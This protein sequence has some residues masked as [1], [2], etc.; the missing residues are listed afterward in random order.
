MATLAQTKK[1]MVI[2]GVNLLDGG[3]LTVLIDCIKAASQCISKEEWQILVFVHKKGLVP[4]MEGITQLEVPCAKKSWLRRMYVEWCHFPKV[5]SK[6]KPDV[7]LSLHDITPRI[8]ARKMAVYCHNPSPFLPLKLGTVLIDPKL[9]LFRLMYGALYAL[10]IQR[11]DWVIVQQNWMA[12]EFARRYKPRRMIVARPEPQSTTRVTSEPSAGSSPFVFFYPA[13]PRSFKNFEQICEALALLEQDP[14]WRHEI[15]FTVAGNENKYIRKVFSRYEH[16][17]SVRWLGLMPHPEVLARYGKAGCL[18]FPS[19]LETWGL[20]LSEAKASGLPILAVDLPYAH[21]TVGDYDKVDF[22]PVDDSATLAAM[23]RT[24]AQGGSQGF[25]HQQPPVNSR[26]LQCQ[27]W[28]QLLELL[29]AS[30]P[31]ET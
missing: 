30:E 23:M 13:F 26:H 16:L 1:T 7:W 21:E 9:A 2:T 14:A 31:C 19:T 12:D 15:W 17:R 28:P 4:E 27:N 6:L 11:N 29:T 18:I 20:P 22:F 25:L 3:P 5:A 24:V 10:N 8:R